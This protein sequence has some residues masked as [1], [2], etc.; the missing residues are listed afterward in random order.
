[1]F[2]QIMAKEALEANKTAQNRKSMLQKEL[3]EH[4]R[5]K[6]FAFLLES[7]VHAQ[8]IKIFQSK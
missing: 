2:Y 4:Q 3:D 8:A 5:V 7:E 6:G 1:M